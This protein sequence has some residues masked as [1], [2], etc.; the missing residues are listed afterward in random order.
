[1]ARLAEERPQE[2]VADDQP[3]R[4]L[5]LRQPD[6]RR[7]VR[8]GHQLHP[9]L[10]RSNKNLSMSQFIYL[11]LA[12]FQFSVLMFSVPILRLLPRAAQPNSLVPWD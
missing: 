1:M 3:Q 12:N 2:D 7:E 9:L 11:I 6:E 5:P 10:R 8:R 4:P